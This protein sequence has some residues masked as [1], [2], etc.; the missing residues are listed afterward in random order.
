[1]NN[2]NKVLVVSPHPDDETLGA[3]GTLLKYKKQGHKIYWLNITDVNEEFG[4]D[5]KRIAHRQEQIEAIRGFFGFDGYYNLSLPT[6]KLATIDE[7]DIIS[8][9]RAVFDDVQPSWVLIPGQYDAHSDHRIVYNCCMAAAKSFRSPYIKR[10]TTMEIVSETDFGFQNER[11]VPNLFVDITEEM[12]KKL[13][14]M[15]IYD[16]EIEEVPFP[17]SLENIKAHSLMWGGYCNSR[18]AEAFCIVKQIE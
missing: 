12:D 7:G 3:G 2:F 1:M 17:R 11:F 8:K 14:A 10:I 13:E 18:Y 15:K 4:W 6:T 9:I 5:E 16:T